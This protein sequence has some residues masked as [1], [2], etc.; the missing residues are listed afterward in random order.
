MNISLPSLLLHLLVKLCFIHLL[1]SQYTTQVKYIN[2][3]FVIMKFVIMKF[4]LLFKI[5]F[6]LICFIKMVLQQKSQLSFWDNII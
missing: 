6:Y 1:F 4:L 5:I 3:Y 2:M